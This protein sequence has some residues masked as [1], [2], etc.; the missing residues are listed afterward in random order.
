MSAY[1]C[2]FD[3]IDL[4]GVGHLPTNYYL[5]WF[6]SV[7]S[8]SSKSNLALAR[9]RGCITVVVVGKETGGRTEV[10]DLL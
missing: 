8:L 10:V 5:L 3:P 6:S 7:E 2:G 1:E 4:V 9:A